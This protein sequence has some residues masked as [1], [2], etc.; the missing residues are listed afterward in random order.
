[1]ISVVIPYTTDGCRWNELRYAVRSIAYHLQID[2]KIILVSEALPTWA[3]NIELLEHHRNSGKYSKVR[4]SWEKM[5]LILDSDSV[6]DDFLY[7]YDDVYLL[8]PANINFWS[9][10]YANGKLD[11][12]YRH[13]K[14]VYRSLLHGTYEAIQSVRPTLYNFETHLPRLFNKEK[15]KKL[16]SIYEPVDKKLLAA[17]L[18]FNFFYDKQPIFLS[19]SDVIKAGF[20]G[21]DSFDSFASP[22]TWKKAVKIMSDKFFLNH[23]DAGLNV[24]LKQYIMRKFNNK[25]KYEK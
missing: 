12:R 21:R 14:N 3:I 7:W 10:I 2:F 24:A 25:C 20:F 23:N 11:D 9:K 15:M 1:M 22:D 5:R 13:S 17:S 18:Y 4:D 19:R 16:M 6:S 8:K